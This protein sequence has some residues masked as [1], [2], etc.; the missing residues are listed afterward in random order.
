MKTLLVLVT[1]ALFAF[2]ATA[3][4]PYIGP[5]T[6]V[7][8]GGA[9]PGFTH[10]IL[11]TKFTGEPP[12]SDTI[13][14]CFEHPTFRLTPEQAAPFLPP[15]GDP[16]TVRQLLNESGGIITSD[17]YDEADP[18]LRVWHGVQGC[19]AQLR[20]WSVRLCGLAG[21]DCGLPYP[22]TDP[23]RC[24]GQV[25]WNPDGNGDD[26]VGAPD[27]SYWIQAFGGLFCSQNAP[28]PKNCVL[29][30]GEG[31]PWE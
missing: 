8:Q 12:T 28:D 25:Y 18:T 6:T 31:P 24:A 20:Q 2:A 17:A 15:S 11:S 19:G 16:A 21:S 30:A 4:S 3:Q 13:Q 7:G 10:W 26:V 5:C 1:S 22:L 14:L 9:G 27:Y 29:G 23:I